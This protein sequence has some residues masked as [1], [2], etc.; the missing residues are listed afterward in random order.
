M[1]EFSGETDLETEN[2]GTGPTSANDESG[3]EAST[4]RLW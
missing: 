3:F 4:V 2:P 1:R